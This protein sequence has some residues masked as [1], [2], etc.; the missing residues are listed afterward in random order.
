MKEINELIK[1]RFKEEET[2]KDKKYFLEEIT[3]TLKYLYQE[4]E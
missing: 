2:I 1:E 4:L 3:K